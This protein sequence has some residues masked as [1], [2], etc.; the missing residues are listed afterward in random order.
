MK[1]LRFLGFFLVVALIGCSD[2]SAQ[3]DAAESDDDGIILSIGSDA[4][5]QA[6]G[7]FTVWK[8]PPVANHP[9]VDF[10]VVI[11][12]YSGSAEMVTIPATLDGSPVIGIGDF[13]FGN[14]TSI[15]SILIPAGV[16]GIGDYAFQNCTALTSVTLPAGIKKIKNGVFSGCT[17]LASIAIPGAVTKIENYAFNGCSNLVSITLPVTKVKI[18]NTAFVACPA[19]DSASQTVIR[20]K[21]YK[22]TF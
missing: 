15:T 5:T 20:A 6:I 1:C 11:T 10:G 18:E 2:F 16:K 19:L 14:N 3:P 12:E 4:I 21:G 22:G 17:A 7:D 8:H 13:A 9:T